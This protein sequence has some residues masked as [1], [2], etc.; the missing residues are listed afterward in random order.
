MSERGHAGPACR[1]RQACHL[2]PVRSVIAAAWAV[3]F[4]A[5]LAAACQTSAP[6]GSGPVDAADEFASCDGG[7]EAGATCEG[8]NVDGYCSN[9]YCSQGAWVLAMGCPAGMTQTPSLTTSCGPGCFGLQICT[10]NNLPPAT[11]VCC[12]P[13]TDAPIDAP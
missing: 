4:V 8:Y 13:V 1:Q 3:L 5:G 6:S 9:Y 12:C 2:P 11:N 10:Y 7:C